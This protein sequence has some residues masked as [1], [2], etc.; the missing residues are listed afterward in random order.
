MPGLENQVAVVT[1]SSRGLGRAIAIEMARE[2]AAVVVNY[3]R[4]EAEAADVAEEIAKLGSRCIVERADVSQPDQARGLINRALEE[5]GAVDVL[6]NNAGIVRDRT[7]RKLT[8][9]DWTTVLS[10][11]LNSA[12]YCTSAAAPGMIERQY[13]RIINVS[14]FVGQSGNIGQAN[15]AASKA[16]L[17][18]L[19]KTLALELARYNI[20]V[21]AVA[22]GFLAT[23]MVG[24][25]SDEIQ[26]K[27]KQ[28]IPLRRFGEPD[29]VAR[30]ITFIAAQGGYITGA[31]LNINGGVYM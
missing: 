2:G 19:T 18:G 23:D 29:E 30:F 16:G 11:N 1:G 6:V 25:I 31:E 3:N 15:Y 13:G 7:L 27:I 14:S 5:F 28:R 20:T 10:N 24:K 4:G 17:I 12:F 22:P 21:N 26:E 9:E 8:D